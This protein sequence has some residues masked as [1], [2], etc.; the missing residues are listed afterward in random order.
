MKWS[1]QLE[2]GN[3]IVMF[4]L[5]DVHEPVSDARKKT[6]VLDHHEHVVSL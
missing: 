6:P 5:D 4:K 1:S 3:V 2:L